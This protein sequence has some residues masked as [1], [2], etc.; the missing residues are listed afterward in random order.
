MRGSADLFPL[1]HE[2]LPV[3][4]HESK[5]LAHGVQHPLR[6]RRVAPLVRPL[7]DE[8]LLAEDAL[9]AI[10]DVAVSQGEVVLDH[11]ETVV[12]G[13][14]HR[15][16]RPRQRQREWA[17]VPAPC[18]RAAPNRRTPCGRCRGRYAA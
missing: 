6:F 11:G 10:G 16:D 12:V 15:P 9:L 8:R 1:A 5:G 3:L 13:L 17:G 7:G 2:D 4:T 14:S 18:C